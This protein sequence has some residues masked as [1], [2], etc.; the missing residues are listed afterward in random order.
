MNDN[1]KNINTSVPDS[2]NQLDKSASTPVPTTNK[3][4][5]G[6]MSRKLRHGLIS[7]A[8]SLLVL[9]AFVLVNIIAVVLTEKYSPL[10]ADITA[11]KSFEITEQS[12]KIAESVTKK[13]TITFLSD[14]K[15]YTDIDP[16]CKQTAYMAEEMHKFSNGMIDV[17]YVDI[18]RNPA[19]ADQYSSEDLS[20]TDIIVSCGDNSRILTASDLFNFQYYSDNYQYIASSDS[21]QALDNAII[22]VT[23][24]E[25]T[26]VVFISDNC[27]QD[28]SYFSKTL[29][30]NG[31][32]VAELS[33]L[34]SDI[35]DDTDM[36][37][38]Y[39]PS[40]DY[41]EE[42]VNKLKEF[43]K[44]GGKYDKTLLF[45]ADSQDTDTPYLD[46]L[47]A[48][49]GL[50][51]EH[52]F[53]FEADS[54]NINSSSTNF[55][56]G[57]M[58]QYFSDLYTDYIENN[59]P[60]ICGYSRAVTINNATVAAPLLSYSDYSGV[61]PFDADDS[62]NISDAI[63]GKTF[64]LA[65]GQDGPVDNASTIV[66]AGTYRLFTKSY[67]GSDYSNRTYFST[68]LSSVNH[69]KLN[70]ISVAEK[71][72]SEFDINISQQTAVNLG[73]VVYALIPIVILGIGFA[74]FLLR[75][76]R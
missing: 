70:Q 3:K 37:V 62:W 11:V 32:T 28:Y 73:F 66:L 18:V 69:R 4:T 58:C 60:V 74:V 12:R 30:A 47:L 43:L 13:V 41:S 27:S 42:A 56:D 75:K 8:V 35:P 21:E 19:F 31:Y 15:T 17:Q 61:C 36:V 25:T 45:A 24:D 54:N 29:Q 2:N 65:Q 7:A 52:G 48:S 20:T 6:P 53:A 55:Y 14:K 51:L 59:R 34:T 10:T 57:I 39:A 68:L 71:V 49:Y 64:V 50:S 46:D 63:T 9:A 72:I 23:N 40:R 76:R 22:G 38:I 33:L 26:N 5:P 67:Y 16:Y 44:N 1:K